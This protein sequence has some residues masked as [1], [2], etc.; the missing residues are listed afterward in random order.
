MAEYN[1]D[2]LKSHALGTF[3]GGMPVQEPTAK[4]HVPPK[5]RPHGET[6]A[7]APKSARATK[8]EG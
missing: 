8:A 6:E 4:E 1:P 2:C 5:K 3:A 7:P